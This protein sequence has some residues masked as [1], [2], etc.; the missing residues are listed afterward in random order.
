MQSAN[1]VDNN[2]IKRNQTN[3]HTSKK[4]C[5]SSDHPLDVTWESECIVI[6]SVDACYV[7]FDNE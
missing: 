3:L 6:P 7:L 4:G 2:T 1:N 5:F